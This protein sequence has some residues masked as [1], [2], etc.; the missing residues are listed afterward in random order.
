MRISDWSSDVCSS[1]L[2]TLL[3]EDEI[4]PYAISAAGSDVHNEMRLFT[5]PWPV[6]ELRKLGNLRVTLRVALS[7]FI[8][9]N[10][11]EPARGS[12]Y[13]YASHN[14]RFKLNRAGENAQQSSEERSVGKE[15]VSTFRSGW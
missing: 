10:L 2:L 14:L 9:P 5:L 6:E 13:R 4:I 12:R 11:S 8:A 7:S 1:D 3:V 15:C